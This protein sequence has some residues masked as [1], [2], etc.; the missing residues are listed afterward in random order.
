MLL[1]L[2]GLSTSFTL[3]KLRKRHIIHKKI[4]TSN[5]WN[6]TYLVFGW[7]NLGDSTVHKYGWWRVKCLWL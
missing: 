6:I 1:T 4:S 7:T 3:D 5:Y 2:K